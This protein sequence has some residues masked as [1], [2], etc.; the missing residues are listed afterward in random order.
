MITY[1]PIIKGRE[2]VLNSNES[3]RIQT[4]IGRKGLYHVM[5]RIVMIQVQVLNYKKIGQSYL[6][7]KGS[8]EI[9]YKSNNRSKLMEYRS[10]SSL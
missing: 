3:N 7:Y 9:L 2:I 4:Q 1:Y 6:K 8:A 10:N 5:K